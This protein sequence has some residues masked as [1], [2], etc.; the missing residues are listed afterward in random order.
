[1]FSNKNCHQYWLRFI[2][3]WWGNETSETDRSE[4][5]VLKVICYSHVF[6][7][8]FFL[9]CRFC[10]WRG[11]GCESSRHLVP[12]LYHPSLE[13]W[14]LLHTHN[15]GPGVAAF[16]FFPLDL[17]HHPP[18]SPRQLSLLQTSL[19]TSVCVLHLCIAQAEFLRSC[20]CRNT[21]G[22]MSSA[23]RVRDLWMEDRPF[24]GT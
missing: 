4:L 1:M 20:G 13:L 14:F 18:Q 6:I 2:T 24:A 8:S 21:D 9:V 10:S 17:H 11:P 19:F 22:K 12:H 16:L 3:I 5:N 15:T 23:S 7:S